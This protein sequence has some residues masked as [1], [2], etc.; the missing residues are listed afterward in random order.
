MS[1][2]IRGLDPH[3]FAHLFGAPESILA[4]HGAQR[5][6]VTSKPSAP[7]RIT[8][9]DAEIGESVLLVSYEHQPAPTAYR[10]AG[11]IF[12]RERLTPGFDG[13]DAIPPALA[14]RPISLR[15]YDAA[16]AM[17]AA[18]LT[19]GAELKAAIAEMWAISDIAYAHAHYALRG[20]FAALVERA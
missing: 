2:R 9:E 5:H 18:M 16:G 7:C 15:G 20:C 19:P 1:F 12:L 13:R 6:A 3:P 11:P 14:V 10:Q 17:A 4:A 8:L